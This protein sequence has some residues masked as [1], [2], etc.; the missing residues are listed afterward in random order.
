MTVVADER[1]EAWTIAGPG[2]LTIV[3]LPGGELAVWSPDLGPV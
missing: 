1:F 3:C 2:G